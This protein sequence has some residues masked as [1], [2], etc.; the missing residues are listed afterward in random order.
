MTKRQN[1]S[2]D[3]NLLERLRLVAFMKHNTLHGGIKIELENAIKEYLLKEEKKLK[4]MHSGKDILAT[5]AE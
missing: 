3:A 5:A 2:I 1:A 4:E